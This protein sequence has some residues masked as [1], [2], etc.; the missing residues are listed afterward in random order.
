MTAAQLPT[1]WAD[2]VLGDIAEIIQGQSPPGSTY[3]ELGAGIPFF[4]GKAEFGDLYPTAVKWTTAPTKIAE[5]DNVLI[6]IRAPVGPT[7]LAPGTC[8]IGR[9]L[10]AIRPRDGVLARYLLFGLRASVSSLARQGTGSTFQAISG[11]VLR[12][13]PMPLAPPREQYRIVEAIETRFAKLDKTVEILKSIVGEDIASDGGRI[14]QLRRSI[15]RGAFEGRLVPQN[16]NDESATAL[17]DRINETCRAASK[18]PSRAQQNATG[19]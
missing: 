3:N 4:Q 5:R 10:A 18:R 6:S 14:G 19:A 15:L 17:L 8:C 13:H 16:P 12:A 2:A 9:G 7:N 11:Q 1:G